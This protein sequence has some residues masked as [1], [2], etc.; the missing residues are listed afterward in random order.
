[1]RQLL[2]VSN[3]AR[4]IVA[5][6]L[7]AILETARRNNGALGITGLLIYID[8]GF[9][10]VLEGEDG[11]VGE[12]YARV[13]ADKRHWNTRVLL[14]REAPRAFGQWSMGFER[15]DGEDPETAGMFGVTREAIAGKLSPT[16]GKVVA[17]MLETF[18]RVQTG[19]VLG[20]R[21]RA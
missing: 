19:D 9:L 5:S 20:L 13:C 8:G 11:P 12:I 4:D 3:C 10:Q 18:Y 17:T 21:Q 7:N 6:D 2:Y 16:A 1:M 14:D 15:L